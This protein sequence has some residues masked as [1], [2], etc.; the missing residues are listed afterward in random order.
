MNL[1][2]FYADNSLGRS[3]VKALEE[4]AFAKGQEDE[5]AKIDARVKVAKPIMESADYP[6]AIKNLAASV[7]A[8]EVSA[9]AL[10][11]TV[12]GFDAAK[13]QAATDAA[14]AET[15]EQ[16]DTPPEA[17]ESGDGANDADGELKS[18]AD[19][20]AEIAKEKGIVPDKVGN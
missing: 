1:Q 8:G 20:D 15:E 2:E 18:Q 4:E 7:V 3:E 19:I 16:G 13:E 12:V 10:T 9:D 5:R 14:A 6:N 17:P 11:A